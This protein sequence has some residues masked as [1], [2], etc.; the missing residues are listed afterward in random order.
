[1]IAAN[2]LR[3][4]QPEL[5]DLARLLIECNGGRGD[6]QVVPFP[7]DRKAIDIGDYYAV[8]PSVR[9]PDPPSMYSTANAPAFTDE[10][11]RELL[12]L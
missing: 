9:N 5:S 6:I 2:S 12:D 7:P 4:A 1:M 8:R 10:E 3:A 11:L